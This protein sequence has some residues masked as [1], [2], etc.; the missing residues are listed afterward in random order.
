[1]ENHFYTLHFTDCST[2]SDVT[3]NIQYE[4]R[5]CFF[6]NILRFLYILVSYTVAVSPWQSS[7]SYG[8]TANCLLGDV[9]CDYL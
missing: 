4:D 2:Y 8:Q 3:Q 5:H 9:S 6:C 1:M 7:D